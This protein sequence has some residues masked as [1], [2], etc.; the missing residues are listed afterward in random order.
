MK[1]S[2]TVSICKEHILQVE[3]YHN[4]LCRNSD[5]HWY[6]YLHCSNKNNICACNSF[7]THFV[8][9]FYLRTLPFPRA[10]PRAA[11]GHDICSRTHAPHTLV[12][13]QSV[14]SPNSSN[15]RCLLGTIERSPLLHYLYLT[16]N[17]PTVSTR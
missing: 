7:R 15:L 8:G 2:L 17:F 3:E 14:L 5:V 10:A 13:L 16:K 6:R 4:Y 1:T 9:Y 12:P 11:A